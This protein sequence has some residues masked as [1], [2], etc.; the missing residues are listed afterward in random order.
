MAKTDKKAKK[1]ENSDIFQVAKIVVAVAVV[2]VAIAVALASRGSSSA[3]TVTTT[4]KAPTPSPPKKAPVTSTSNEEIGPDAMANQGPLLNKLV[5]LLKQV[6]DLPED[7]EERK[8]ASAYVS[9]QLDEIE[10]EVDTSTAA[11]KQHMG[12]ITLARSALKADLD[13]VNASGEEWNE[14][15]LFKEHGVITYASK[16]YWDEAYAGGKYGAAYDWYGG[17]EE[18]DQDKNSLSEVVRPLLAKQ[19]EKKED[20]QILT[21]GA[22]ISNMSTYIYEDGYHS[23]LNTD[24]SEPAM[25]AMTERW[26]HLKGMTWRTMDASE[27]DLKNESFDIVVEKGLFDAL[28]AG[29]GSRANV[30]LEEVLR[31]LRPGG[32]I[33]SISFGHDRFERLFTP[34]DIPEGENPLKCQIAK[35]LRFKPRKKWKEDGSGEEVKERSKTFVYACEK[36]F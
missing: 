25:K 4:T 31:V 2:F 12:F 19:K 34:S 20:P 27:M 16:K 22:G 5:E 14:E 24:I 10:K 18:L 26:G 11:G 7:G 35:E 36:M 8:K 30:V 23:I 21:L 13:G 17:W 28:F 1:E 9:A 32:L 3:A 29:T 33:V 15:T 6:D